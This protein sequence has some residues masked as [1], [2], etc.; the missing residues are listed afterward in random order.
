MPYIN[1]ISQVGERVKIFPGFMG[2]FLVWKGQ[3]HMIKWGV[4]VTFTHLNPGVMFPYQV[5]DPGGFLGL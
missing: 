1:I 3:I 2:F 5:D 4:T